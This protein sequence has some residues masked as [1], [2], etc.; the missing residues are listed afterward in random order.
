MI[1][2]LRF[3]ERQVLVDAPQYGEGYSI[4]KIERV[5]QA[6]DGHEW[7]DVPLVG[8]INNDN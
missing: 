7:V 1:Q 2:K 8:E 3:V 6:Y 4:V 5:L